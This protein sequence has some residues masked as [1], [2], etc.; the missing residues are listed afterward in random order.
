MCITLKVSQ[1]RTP[2]SLLV[3]WFSAHLLISDT[4]HDTFSESYGRL[5]SDFDFQSVFFQSVFLRSVPVCFRIVMTSHILYSTLVC[6][7]TGDQILS[8]DTFVTED[9]ILSFPGGV[10]LNI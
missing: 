6:L 10:L 9:Q 5:L 2:V 7:V 1:E 4:E 3:G 8:I